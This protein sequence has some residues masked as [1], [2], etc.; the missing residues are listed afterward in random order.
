MID[1]PVCNFCGSQDPETWK[2]V[3]T[4]R[5]E[6][7]SI[8]LGICGVCM[9]AV[10]W[11]EKHSGSTCAICGETTR[12]R[13]HI[14][15]PGEPHF[16]QSGWSVEVALCRDCNNNAGTMM[17]M[18]ESDLRFRARA[19]VLY[20]WNRQRRFVLHRDGFTCKDCGV[21]DCRLHVH[22]INPRSEGGTNHRDNLVSLCPD[23]HARRH[24][25]DA[26]LLCGSLT[27]SGATWLDTSG[28]GWAAFCAECAK[29][30]RKNGTSKRCSICARFGDS[31]R[32]DGIYWTPKVEDDGKVD[33]YS[34]C[35]ECRSN[36]LLSNNWKQR[37]EYIEKTL[38]DS[39]VDVAHWERGD[40][41]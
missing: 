13:L 8:G 3:G 39:H 10:E 24:G 9:D 11:H 23:C 37:F 16:P 15:T 34:A 21:S 1:E 38:P 6:S 26:C 20:D 36:L 14:A 41:E 29:Y 2:E 17:H 30:I 18:W 25:K 4:H 5:G 40:L 28:G 22:H 32:S 35:D 27:D 12:K 7:G 19:N 33:V 31:N